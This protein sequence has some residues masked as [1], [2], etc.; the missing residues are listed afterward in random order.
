MGYARCSF[1]CL[2]SSTTS[3]RSEV[4]YCVVPAYQQH[5]REEERHR[6]LILAL[7]AII[8][9]QEV[10]LVAGD[11]NGTAWRCC[12]RN[13]LSTFYEAFTD[14]A[15]PTPPGSTPFVETWINSGQL[16]RRLRI[17]SNHQVLTVFFFGKCTSMVHSPSHGKPLVYVPPI[18]VTI[19]TYG[20]IWT[21]WIGTTAGPSKVNMIGTF[22][23]KKDLQLV[24]TGTRKDVLAKS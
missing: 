9:S 13:N 2:I 3:Q 16:G 5:L 11:F 6:Q 8:I 15:F 1:T 23:S 17:F 20:F 14:C 18:K 21:S 19:T 12:S 7:C 22:P 24:H 10:D 4:L